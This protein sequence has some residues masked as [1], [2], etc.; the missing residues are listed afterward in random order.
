MSKK[1]PVKRYEVSGQIL[2]RVSFDKKG[3]R[4]RVRGFKSKK[5]A[6]EYASTA[7]TKIV[8]GTYSEWLAS[9]NKKELTFS[10]L[11]EL[12]LASPSKKQR[13]TTIRA[14]S[15]L[16]RLHL[17]EY[18]GSKALG[19]YNRSMYFRW[20]DYKEKTGSVIHNA[21]AFLKVLIKFAF[22]RGYIEAIPTVQ[23][24]YYKKVKAH[25]LSAKL[26]FEI[27]EDPM[28]EQNITWRAFRNFVLI[29]FYTLSRVGEVAALKKEDIDFE[30]GTM[31]I[32]SSYNQGVVGKTKTGKVIEDFPVNAALERVLK[33]QILIAGK[34]D[35]LFP[36]TLMRGQDNTAHRKPVNSPQWAN[37]KWDTVCRTL[38]LPRTASHQVRKAA[39]SH[40][41]NT[42]CSIKSAERAARITAAMILK[43]YTDVEKDRFLKEYENAFQMEL[44]RQPEAEVG[45]S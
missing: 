2:W 21:S 9:L 39:I 15:K 33:E 24:R 38:E 18:Y 20:I 4:V 1:S 32:R 28:F 14:Y 25:T 44:N 29:Q 11:F 34:S 40:L 23:Y 45:D 5:A 26:L 22:E 19:D 10:E 31:A 27:L 37:K 35:F 30:S 12:W 8:L 41:V 3:F 43:H 42:G 17:S 36:A 7:E 16:W 6:E 13:E